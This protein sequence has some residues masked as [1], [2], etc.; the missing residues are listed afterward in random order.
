MRVDFYEFGRITV[1]GKNYTHDLLILPDRIISPWWRL[2]GHEVSLKDLEI[3]WEEKTTYLVI[4][5]GAY[6]MMRV[7]EE[8]KKK[9]AELGIHLIARK[10]AEAVKIY[11][12]YE[13]TKQVIGA[14]HLTC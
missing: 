12:Q 14:F 5:T 8:V 3:V 11:N 9:T 13:P 7:A 2:E 6:G 1:E 4:G 10:T